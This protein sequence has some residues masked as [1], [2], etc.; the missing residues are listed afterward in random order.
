MTLAVAIHA[1]FRVRSTSWQRQ[2]KLLWL[3]ARQLANGQAPV[4][5]SFP[6]RQPRVRLWHL[7]QHTLIL[8]STS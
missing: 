2:H 7:Q 3:A 8:F 6:I 1:T 5:N 4:I